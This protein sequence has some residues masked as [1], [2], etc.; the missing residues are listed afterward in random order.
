MATKLES[1]GHLGFHAATLFQQATPAQVK[2]EAEE[3]PV[4]DFRKDQDGDKQFCPRRGAEQEEGQIEYKLSR[5]S[6]KDPQ[7]PQEMG[8]KGQRTTS[9]EKLHTPNWEEKETRAFLSIWGHEHLQKMLQHQSQDEEVYKK[10]AGQMVALG[11]DR[12]WEQCRQRAKELCRGY[13]DVRD[14]NWHTECGRQMWQY[15]EDLDAIP[16][17]R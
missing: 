1:H 17:C 13:K 14:Q 6:G 16:G 3:I 15:F 11:Y 7:S 5:V 8:L 9:C 2:V 10:I 12:D 4:S